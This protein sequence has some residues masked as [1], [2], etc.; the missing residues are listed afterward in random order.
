MSTRVH[1]S[2]E[3]CPDQ[4]ALV[5]FLYD[6]FDGEDAPDRRSLTRHVESC[7]RCARILASLGGVRQRLQSWQVPERSP[8]ASSRR[9]GVSRPAWRMAPGP[10]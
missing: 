3:R 7:D 5:S 4:E 1:F 8:S 2:H 10:A 9:H 6:E